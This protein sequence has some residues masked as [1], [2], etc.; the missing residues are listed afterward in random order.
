MFSELEQGR[1]RQLPR[2]KSPPTFSSRKIRVT[3]KPFVDVV[4]DT[5]GQKGT[6][7]WTSANA[8]DMGVPAPTIAESVFA[9]CLSAVKEERVA[10]S[11][12][13][14]GRPR[15]RRSRP[16]KRHSSKPSTT[17]STAPRSVPTPR[18]S[19]SCAPPRRNTV[20]TQLRPD[21]PDLP[22]WLHHPRRLPAK[23][24]RG[25]SARDPQLA[26]LL[27]DE[28]FNK[29]IQKAQAN[30]RKV[31]SSRW[32]TAS[33]CP[34][35]LRSQLLRRLPLRPPAGQ[36]APGSARLLRRPH[37]RARGPAPR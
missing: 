24:H 1:A 17:P 25:L 3:G 27:L 31:V 26:N 23:D 7:K 37:L 10:A 4:L 12:L 33:A 29:T 8:L 20:E 35:S 14:K 19:S 16:R 9:R 34:P 5:A 11:K 18:A 36:L 13:P 21:R 28:Y 2:S 6:G 32:K 30:W 22:R 15:S